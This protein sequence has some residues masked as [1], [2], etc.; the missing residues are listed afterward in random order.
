MDTLLWCT[1]YNNSKFTEYTEYTKFPGAGRGG[2]VLAPVMYVC[3]HH[4][5]GQCTEYTECTEFSC[6]VTGG[7][8][9][10]L[11]LIMYE[12]IM[13]TVNAQSAP[14]APNSPEC[15]EFPCE[16]TGATKEG[17]TPLIYVCVHYHNGQCIEFTECT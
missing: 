16:G 8:R 17:L 5:N 13:I 7:D 3:T 9:G 15:T 10:S 6:V 11:P 4:Y 1:H 12:Y 14:T 2:K